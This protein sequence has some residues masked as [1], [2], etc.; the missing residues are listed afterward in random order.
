LQENKISQ[1]PKNL[2]GW[3]GFGVLGSDINVSRIPSKKLFS[4]FYKTNAIEQTKYLINQQRFFLRE[5]MY[6]RFWN[7][8]LNNRFTHKLKEYL[9]LKK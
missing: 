9:K 1:V 8:F 5:K 4:T 2:E 7:N 6:S 3:S